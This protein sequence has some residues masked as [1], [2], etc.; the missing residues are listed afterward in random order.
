MDT[1]L[2]NSGGSAGGEGFMRQPE[3]RHLLALQV[4]WR[5]ALAA[6]KGRPESPQAAAWA[7]AGRSSARRRVAAAALRAY[8]AAAEA[9]PP[10]DAY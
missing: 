3:V 2:L 7:I 6:A 8:T 9:K 4:S 10:N 5:L 1:E